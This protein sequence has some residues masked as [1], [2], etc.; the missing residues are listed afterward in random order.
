MLA[1]KDTYI[2]I[3]VHN[4]KATTL[5]CLSHLKNNGD[6]DNYQVVIVD[7][8]S[9][10]GTAEAIKATYL[11]ITVLPGDGDLWWTGGIALG[12]EYAHAQGAK[13]IIW[14]N[15]D[16]LPEPGTLDGLI[17]YIRV[18]PSTL[19]A[20]TCYVGSLDGAHQHNGFQGRTG[21]NA[22]TGEI[23][24]VNGMSGWCVAMPAS[25]IDQVGL[26]NTKR[27]PHYSGDDI[28][29]LQVTKA[30][31]HAYLLGDLAAVL[32]GPVHA[33]LSFRDYFRPGL[34]PGKILK[35]LFWDKK[36][37]YRLPTRLFVMAERYGWIQG[38][39]LFSTKLITWLALYGRF[40]MTLW[41]NPSA[42]KVNS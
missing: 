42:F 37:P 31:Y 3:P 18:K 4:R 22:K 8:G 16:C 6:L 32:Y 10:D 23:L 34:K 7:D 17:S 2:V 41:L 9:T 25:V 11:D 14:L 15:D 24:E 39:F 35:S 12:M 5:N 28:Y 20:P 29:T 30:G 21:C 13:F 19:A 26:P 33:Q 38:L 1:V 27:F 36:S 40:Q